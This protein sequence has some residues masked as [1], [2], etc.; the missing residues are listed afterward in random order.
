[1]P[2]RARKALSRKRIPCTLLRDMREGRLG[3]GVRVGTFD[4]SKGL[5]F[6][7]VFIPRIGASVFPQK[8]EGRY[9][10]RPIPGLAAAVRE[11]TDEEREVRQLDLDRLYVGMTRAKETLYL[12]ADE[13]PCP[14]WTRP[15]TSSSGGTELE[16][17][18]G[19]AYFRRRTLKSQ[20]ANNGPADQI[21]PLSAGDNPATGP[22]VRSPG[23]LYPAPLSDA[24]LVR[25]AR[26]G[27]VTDHVDTTRETAA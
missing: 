14:N 19:A 9:L 16:R 6:R 13:E 7:A 15:E 23:L 12:V 8:E 4:R 24:G 11:T 18:L 25:H 26:S 3:D 20:Y 22:V 1:M 10:Q 17:R 21:A 2:T 27:N 5:E